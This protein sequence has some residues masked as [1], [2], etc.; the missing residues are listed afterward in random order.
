MGSHLVCCSQLQSIAIR[1]TAPDPSKSTV[2]CVSPNGKASFSGFKNVLHGVCWI[3]LVVAL[4]LSLFASRI[5]MVYLKRVPTSEDIEKMLKVER[6][7]EITVKAAAAA[8]A[9]TTATMAAAKAAAT[10]AA[11]DAT[12]EAKAAA[13]KAA[14]A[15]KKMASAAERASLVLSRSK[16]S[17]VVAVTTTAT[18]ITTTPPPPAKETEASKITTTAAA[19]ATAAAEAA[20]AAAAKETEATEITTTTAAAAAQETTAATA[21]ATTT[22]V[23]EATT[24]AAATATAAK[25]AT[26]I[27]AVAAEAAK[28]VAAT[29]TRKAIEAAAKANATV[30]LLWG[31]FILAF[32]STVIITPIIDQEANQAGYFEEDYYHFI[33]CCIVALMLFILCCCYKKKCC[34]VQCCKKVIVYPSL[35][36]AFHHLLWV[37]LGIITEPFWAIPVLV[38]VSSVLFVLYFLV[39]EYYL[40]MDGKFTYTKELWFFVSCFLG[41][42]LLILI[43][44]VVGQAFFSDSLIANVAQSIMMLL[45]PYGVSLLHLE[46]RNKQ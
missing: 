33:F 9:E 32:A 11:A 44:V 43:L 28:E 5:L 26:T 6:R 14:K 40:G 23:K 15:A 31:F 20:A 25:E 34:N 2:K 42:L 12:E 30:F 37:L 29:A 21:A 3:I 36:I 22:A 38:A 13:A 46:N 8:K 18:E 10:T 17:A 45:L 7:A 41:F 1:P 16:S 24:I 19:V 35:F 39:Y 27:A 4:M